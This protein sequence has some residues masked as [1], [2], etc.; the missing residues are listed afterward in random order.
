MPNDHQGR[1]LAAAHAMQSG[2]AMEMK[3]PERH[4]ATEPK[5]LRV[6][7]NTAMS[8]HGALVKLLVDKGF[9]TTAEYMKALAEAMEA[10]KQRYEESL[11][12]RLGKTVTLG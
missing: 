7:I 11:S 1:Y 12:R 10:E 3:L 4:A 8:D 6:G 2:V 9:I 5:H